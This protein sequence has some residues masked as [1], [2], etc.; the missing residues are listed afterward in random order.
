MRK[1]DREVT[2]PA[3]LEAILRDTNVVHLGLWDGE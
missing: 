2:D 3:Q 1:A